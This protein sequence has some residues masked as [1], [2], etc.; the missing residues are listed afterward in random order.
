MTGEAIKNIDES[1]DELRSYV[2]L[3]ESIKAYMKGSSIEPEAMTT[4]QHDLD[5]VNDSVKDFSSSVTSLMYS[6]QQT[7]GYKIKIKIEA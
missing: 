3:L 4:I 2:D 7:A 1:L 5:A 6:V